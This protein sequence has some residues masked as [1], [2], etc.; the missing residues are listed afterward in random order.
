MDLKVEK[1]MKNIESLFKYQSHI[2]NV[3]RKSYV[4]HSGM[5]MRCNKKTFTL[6]NVIHGKT[7][8]YGSTSIIRHYHYRSDPT[9]GPGIFAIRRIP[10]SC[11]A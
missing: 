1:K 7:S 2:Y 9:L 3:Q 11:H 10:C 4:N 6:L 8:L 5:K